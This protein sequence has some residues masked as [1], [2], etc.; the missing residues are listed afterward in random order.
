MHAEDGLH[1]EAL[2]QALFDHHAGATAILLGWLEDQVDGSVEVAVSC[3]FLGCGQQHGGVPIVPT[4][5]HPAGVPARMRKL[6]ELLQGQGVH[7]GSQSQRTATGTSVAPMH[8]AHHT[9]ARQSTVNRNA[10]LGE[11]GG[12]DVGGAF[13]LK[14][15]FRVGVDVAPQSGDASG[16][17]DDAVNQ[18][19]AIHSTGCARIQRAS[20]PMQ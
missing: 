6:V 17:A 9:S 15:E 10:P 14:T 18:I 8:R 13:L 5:V 19:H 1:G 16:L 4:G 7:V 2:E 3:Q 11:F 12:H 20:N